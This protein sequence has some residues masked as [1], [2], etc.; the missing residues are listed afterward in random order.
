LD[1][2]EIDVWR[3][4]DYFA[5]FTKEERLKLEGLLSE[6]CEKQFSICDQSTIPFNSF[7]LDHVT[8]EKYEW[9]AIINPEVHQVRWVCRH[10]IMVQRINN[11]IAKFEGKRILCIAGAD[12]NPYLSSNL[13]GENI[14]LIYPLRR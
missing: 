7:A 11:A 5:V 13:K 8:K 2:L 6:W 14:D 12:H 9:L 4:F 1:W 3:D 10:L